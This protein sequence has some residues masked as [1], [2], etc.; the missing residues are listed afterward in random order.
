MFLF[1]TT[2]VLWSLSCPLSIIFV[3]LTSGVEATEENVAFI[4][5][6]ILFYMLILQTLN[7][8]MLRYFRWPRWF[9]VGFSCLSIVL[10]IF[11][12]INFRGLNPDIY[13]PS[14][15]YLG[16][17]NLIAVVWSG[18][19]YS[20]SLCVRF[21]RRQAAKYQAVHGYDP[22]QWRKDNPRRLF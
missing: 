4:A 19:Y 5:Y 7:I 18:F 15:Y 20:S 3:I 22:I 2:G 9:M 10:M 1:C 8:L 21:I 11:A 17:V 12:I 14:I 6:G 13:Y 16:S